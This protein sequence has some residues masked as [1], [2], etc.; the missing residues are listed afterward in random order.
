[1]TKVFLSCEPKPLQEELAKFEKTITINAVFDKHIVKGSIATFVGQH[2]VEFYCEGEQDF[3]GVRHVEAIGISQLSI[4]T[5]ELILQTLKCKPFVTSF[6]WE[7]SKFIEGGRRPEKVSKAD[8]DNIKKA[9][10]TYKALINNVQQAINF[11]DSKVVDATEHLIEIFN[12]L[13]LIQDDIKSDKNS[14]T[15]LGDKWSIEMQ[16]LNTSSFR[17]AKRDYIVRVTAEDVSNLF[18]YNGKKYRFQ[19]VY[20]PQDRRISVY[21]DPCMEQKAAYGLARKWWGE[22]SEGGMWFGRSPKGVAMTAEDVKA[23]TY[24][25]EGY[26]DFMQMFEEMMDVDNGDATANKSRVA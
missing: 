23:A 6:F 9:Y 24:D 2:E 16:E 25:L 26:L 15:P 22:Q 3:L 8:L 20:N 10:I 12:T 13:I 5:I 19:I 18:V 11:N 21:S 4:E 14:I 17:F 1:M 7:Y